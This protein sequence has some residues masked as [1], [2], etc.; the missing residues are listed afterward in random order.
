MLLSMGLQRVGH[1]WATEQQQKIWCGPYSERIETPKK[2]KQTF[3]E[4]HAYKDM[5]MLQSNLEDFKVPKRGHAQTQHFSNFNVH[6]NYLGF[7]LN[8]DSNP[9]DLKWGC[10]SD[11][12]CLICFQVMLLLMIHGSHSRGRRSVNTVPNEAILWL[13]NLYP[14]CFKKKKS[15]P[16]IKLQAIK[17]DWKNKIK[18]EIEVKGEKV[19]KEKS[20][21]LG[22]SV[23]IRNANLCALNNC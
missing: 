9:V 4:F 8:T 12:A 16:F 19:G 11:S 7:V 6:I 18:E 10:T 20:I 17:Q 2:N 5:T 23:D 22:G 21:S 13:F 1:D 14:L 3:V 15:L